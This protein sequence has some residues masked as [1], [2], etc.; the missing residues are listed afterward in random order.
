[1]VLLSRAHGSA[2]PDRCFQHVIDICKYRAVAATVL[3]LTSRRID[4]VVGKSLPLTLQCLVTIH[5]SKYRPRVKLAQP[6]LGWLLVTMITKP[7]CKIDVSQ[8]R[9]CRHAVPGKDRLLCQG[10]VWT[11]G[12]AVPSRS[13]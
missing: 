11:S 6:S 12:L 7:S 2:K 10:I 4:A 13:G 5:L 1:V 3:I 9:H 8:F